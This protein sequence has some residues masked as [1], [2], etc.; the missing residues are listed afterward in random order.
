MFILL[1]IY[2]VTHCSGGGK[3]NV[4]CGIDLK[5]FNFKTLLYCFSLA[6]Y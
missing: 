4:F 3:R 2:K 1:K 5:N 6:A